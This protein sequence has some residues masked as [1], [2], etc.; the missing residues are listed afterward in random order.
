MWRYIEHYGLGHAVRVIAGWFFIVLG[1]L[2]LVLPVLQGI[3]F[4]AIGAL[5]LAPYV[6]F[7]RRIKVYLFRRFPRMRKRIRVWKAQLAAR[8]GHAGHKTKAPRPGRGA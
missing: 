3:L 1:L 6:P 4:L 7:F 8:I 2:G 5:L